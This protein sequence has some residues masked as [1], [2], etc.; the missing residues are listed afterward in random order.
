VYRAYER[1][2]YYPVRN[3]V[4][5][6][7]DL[8]VTAVVGDVISEEGGKIRHDEEKLGRLL[9]ELICAREARAQQ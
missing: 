6:I 5:E 7:R 8:G 9:M 1:E 3:D 2:G 4:E